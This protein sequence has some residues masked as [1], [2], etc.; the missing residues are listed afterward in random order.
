MIPL[1]SVRR[2]L[3]V[4]DT[5]FVVKLEETKTSEVNQS[6]RTEV[7]PVESLPTMEVDATPSYSQPKLPARLYFSPTLL[8]DDDDEPE[9]IQPVLSTIDQN[10]SSMKDKS[11]TIPRR[12]GQTFL[13]DEVKNE[14]LNESEETENLRPKISVEM[15]FMIQC[16]PTILPENEILN[17]SHHSEAP[18][19]QYET[20]H[21]LFFLVIIQSSSL[22]NQ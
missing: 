5:T 19:H 21:S 22:G 7:P 18:E 1:T 9:L 12:F 16:D 6:S 20:L 14:E 3:P 10:R 15:P 2:T 11:R 13:L 4:V 17:E 8:H